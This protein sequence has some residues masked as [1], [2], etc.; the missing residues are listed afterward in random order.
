MEHLKNI[1]RLIRVEQWTKNAFV[2]LPLFFDRHLW[3]WHPAIEQKNEVL[4]AF[5]SRHNFAIHYEDDLF[6]VLIL[7]YND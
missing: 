6:Q 5:M 1:L 7:E 2:F 3:E 4:A